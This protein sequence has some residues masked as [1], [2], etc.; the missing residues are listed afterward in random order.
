MRIPAQRRTNDAGGM[1]SMIDIVFLLLIFFVVGAAGVVPEKLLPAEL[2]PQGAL[3]GE[4]VQPVPSDRI[5]IWLR[6]ERNDQG[7]TVV[8]MNGTRYTDLTFLKSQLRTLAELDPENPLVLDTAP[9]VPLGDVVD[10]FDTC[11]SAGFQ[12]IEFA[13]GKAS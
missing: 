12:K 2:P 8:D 1:T 11:R 4:T 6:V 10:L 13:T 3:A 7:Q 5:D 9:D